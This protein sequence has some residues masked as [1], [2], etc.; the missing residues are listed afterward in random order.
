MQSTRQDLSHAFGSTG[1]LVECENRSSTIPRIPTTNS[2]SLSEKLSHLCN[3]DGPL[4][5]S[6]FVHYRD[7][8]GNVKPREEMTPFMHLADSELVRCTW[9]LKMTPA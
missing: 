6:E 5:L 4:S 3:H 1:T 9:M 7:V 2:V 8:K